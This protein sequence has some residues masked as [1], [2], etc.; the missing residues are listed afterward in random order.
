MFM[1]KRADAEQLHSVRLRSH[2]QSYS[3][4]DVHSMRF[5]QQPVHCWAAICS[6]KCV[7]LPAK[8]AVTA[9]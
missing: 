1:C 3:C 4:K 5:R 8:N 7:L 2:H 6:S 9:S